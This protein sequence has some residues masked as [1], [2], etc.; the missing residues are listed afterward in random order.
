ML[1]RKNAALTAHRAELI[2]ALFQAD[3]YTANYPDVA[4]TGLDPFEHFLQ[5]GAAE[6]RD[7]SPLFDTAYYRETN[8]DL[9]GFEGPLIFHFV[10]HGGAE[11]RS[12]IPLFDCEFYLDT[13]EDVRAS[14]MNP[15]LHY[16]STGGTEGR[17]TGTLFDSAYYLETNPDIAAGGL[18]PL[19]HFLMAGAH[20]GRNPNPL[21]SGAWYLLHNPDIAEAGLNPLLHYCVAGGHEG[22]SPHPLFDGDYYLQRYHDIASSSQTP[23]DHYLKQGFREDRAPHPLFDPVFYRAQLDHDLDGYDNPLAHYLTH[24]HTNLANPHP[25]FN[26]THYLA[27]IQPNGQEQ[28]NPLVHYCMAGRDGNASPHPLFDQNYYRERRGD[29]AHHG[30]ALLADYVASGAK[31][32]VNPHPLFHSWWYARRYLGGTISTQTPL[33]HYISEGDAAGYN[34]NPYFLTTWFTSYNE[35]EA[36]DIDTDSDAIGGHISDHTRVGLLRY[37]DRVQ[38][39]VRDLKHQIPV[40]HTANPSPWFDV[41]WY[42]A[43]NSDVLD[44]NIDPL[45]HY[46]ET[47]CHERRVP[48]PDFDPEWYLSQHPEISPIEPLHH[49]IE[50]G[51]ALGYAPNPEFQ[52]QRERA[53]GD[54]EISIHYDRRGGAKI[55]PRQYKLLEQSELFVKDWYRER[56]LAPTGNTM[57]PIEHYLVFG[58]NL[59]YN[60]GPEF[61]SKAYR[62]NNHDL[63]SAAINPLLHYIQHGRFEGRHATKEKRDNEVDRF[64]FSPAEYGPISDVLAFDSDH[65][66]PGDLT[67]KICLH[68]HLFHT[69]MADEFCDLINRLTVP[70]TLLVSI[71][72]DQ[73]VSYWTDYFTDHITH[74]KTVIV[75]TCVNRGR[76]VQPW[77][78]DFADD[79]QAHDIF[80]HLHTKK[81]G[82]NKFQRSWRRYLAHTTFGAKTVVNQILDIFAQDDSV[83]LVFPAYFYILRNQPNY[84]KNLDQYERLYAMLFGDLPDEECP[85]YP[86]GSFFWARTAM[87]A[88]LFDLQLSVE[89]FDEEDGQVDG[90]MAHALERILGTLPQ[91]TGHTKRCI[92]VDVPFDLVRY[93]HPA[94]VETLNPSL[95]LPSSFNITHSDNDKKPVPKRRVAVYSSITGGYEDLVRPLTIDPHIDYFLFTDNPEQYSPEW[96]TVI[97]SP[98]ISHKPVRTARYVKTHPH[99]WFNDYD[100]AIWMDANVL[101]VHSLDPIIDQLDGTGFDAAFIQHPLRYNCMEEGG[102]LIRFGLDDQKL[103]EEQLTRYGRIPDIFGEEL[104]ETN[105]FIC[106]PQ[107]AVTKEFFTHW[108]SELNRYSHRDQLSVNYAILKSGLKWMPLFSDNVSLRDHPD[109]FLLEHE[110]FN[111]DEFIKKISQKNTPDNASSDIKAAS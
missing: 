3:W 31:D 81:S 59:G 102:E 97:P 45:A 68:L 17:A 24:G 94:R 29:M 5:A 100:Y 6:G 65:Q 73:D 36:S 86:A 62:S 82:Y 21:F 50:Y 10:D 40:R 64:R 18:A 79:I 92:A 42:L 8:P 51:A 70:F 76:D 88:P 39:I 55:D 32:G 13:Y 87:L 16:L 98:Y 75:K 91:F 2:R 56:Y 67:E 85:D 38:T 60:P 84:G 49:F 83:G 34:P 78:I 101:P 96:A 104:I 77:L 47:G 71:Q 19:W 99:F 4:I 103:I 105:F 111:R 12:P 9:A 25:L 1:G 54:P 46:I 43:E 106:R 44:L 48:G 93:I 11:G 95:Y 28:I 89:D 7:P 27:Q 30:R 110:M 57:D 35:H 107:Q 53:L 26:R 22:R 33:E 14:A 80:C 20:E 74:A 52:R 109:F 72:R 108:W 37:Q 69:D 66:P 63:R 61:N 58:A 41:R 90:T 15:Y 23:L